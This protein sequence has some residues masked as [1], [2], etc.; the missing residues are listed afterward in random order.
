[1]SAGLLGFAAG[2]TVTGGLLLAGFYYFEAI[3][4]VKKN[5]S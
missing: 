4:K 2:S 3:Q 5:T 1:M